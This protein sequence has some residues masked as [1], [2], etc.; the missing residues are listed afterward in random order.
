MNLEIAH[1]LARVRG[2]KRAEPAGSLRRRKETVGDL[3]L[4]IRR[5]SSSPSSW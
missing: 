4:L 5:R 3:E 2:V 1:A